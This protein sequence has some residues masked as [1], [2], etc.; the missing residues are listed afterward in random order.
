MSASVSIIQDDL[1]AALRG[2]LLS[3]VDT[4]EVVLG[5]QNGVSMPA[6]DNFIV[7]TP[8]GQIGLST[9]RVQYDDNG[10][11]GEGKQLTQRSTQWPCQIDCYGEKASAYASII[12]T[13]IRSD[14]ACEWFKEYGPVLTPLYCSDP[15][16]TA[17]INGEQQYEDR[18]TLDFIGQFNP[19][20]TTPRDFM[21]NITVGVIAADLKYPPENA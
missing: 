2:F 12:G 6:A 9:N 1:T 13:L 19:V 8:L 15:R 21:D 14:H 18:W 20:V 10:I 17:M 16:Q 7:M 11:A 3:I 4:D 5:Q